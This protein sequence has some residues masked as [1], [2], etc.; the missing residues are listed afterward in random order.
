MHLQYIFMK[1]KYFYYL[2]IEIYNRLFFKNQMQLSLLD[3]YNVA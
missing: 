2:V 3:L 1:D